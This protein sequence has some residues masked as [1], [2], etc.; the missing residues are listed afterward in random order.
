[1][2][3][4][5]DGDNIMELTAFM[6]PIEPQYMGKQFSNADE[7]VGVWTPDGLHVARIGDVI[8]KDASGNL[9]VRK[10]GANANQTENA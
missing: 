3:I 8:T 5:W 10:E 9:R 4:T 1:M 6:S 2:E 7:I